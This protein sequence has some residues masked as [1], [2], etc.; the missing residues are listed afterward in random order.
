MCANISSPSDELPKPQRGASN[1][2]PSTNRNGTAQTTTTLTTT[3]SNS[4]PKASGAETDI[5]GE[6]KEQRKPPPWR[7]VWEILTWTP[8]NC[9]WDPNKPPQFSMSSMCVFSSLQTGFVFI[10]LFFSSLLERKKERKKG[11]Q[12]ESYFVANKV[13]YVR[14]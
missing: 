5:I 11:N 10:H 4:T 8:P 14:I 13:L 2:A 7:R 6:N 3:T 1:L 12:E 9:R